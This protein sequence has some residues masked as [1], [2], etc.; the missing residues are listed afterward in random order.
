MTKLTERKEDKY[1]ICNLFKVPPKTRRRLFKDVILIGCNLI[2]GSKHLPYSVC[3]EIAKFVD[4]FIEKKVYR[5]QK[6][7]K[8]VFIFVSDQT[9]RVLQFRGKKEVLIKH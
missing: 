7:V 8:I 2:T 6:L 1:L 5:L 3:K 4:F 9:S